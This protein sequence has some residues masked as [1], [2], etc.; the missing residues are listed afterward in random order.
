MKRFCKSLA[1]KVLHK[2]WWKYSSVG[3]DPD[4][5][6]CKVVSAIMEELGIPFPTAEPHRG[7][8]AFHRDVYGRRVLVRDW[9]KRV[10]WRWR[11]R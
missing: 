2:Y 5:E 10:S 11:G 8:R 1:I 3:E 6:K 9:D 4:P 7:R